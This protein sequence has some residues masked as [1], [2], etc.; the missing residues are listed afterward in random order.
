MQSLEWADGQVN[1]SGIRKEVF[2]APKS[3]IQ[4]TP[5]IVSNPTTPEENI[6]VEGDF[7]MKSGK[8]FLRMYSTQ[9]KGKVY[10]EPM[11][12]KDHKMF[13]N[14]GLF[15]FPDISAAARSIA[16]QTIN[17]NIIM[18]ARIPFGSEIRYVMLGDDDYDV[19]V[20]IKGDSGDKPGSEKGMTFEV[21]SPCET[22]LPGYAGLL[23]L[24]DGSLNCE[25]G[26]FTTASGLG[27]TASLVGV[28]SDA[29][30]VNVEIVTT[31]PWSAES[32]QLWC[33]LAPDSGS[34]NGTIVA[35]VTANT[36]AARS[37]I[38]TITP[39][40]GSPVLVEI[41]QSAA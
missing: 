5:R 13:V 2:W 29:A 1:P 12:E 8:T 40:L 33:T 7:V 37:A 22:P 21:E 15:S 41:A 26:V 11:G 16:K 3:W 17:S 18:I 35:S 38:I 32:D 20:T 10:W 25:T 28:G 14:K 34:G 23:P 30:D 39:S 27:I 36:G 24:P 19:T 31:Q 4:T 6:I 9:G